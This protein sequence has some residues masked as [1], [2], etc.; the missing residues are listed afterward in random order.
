MNSN[1]LLGLSILTLNYKNPYKNYITEMN[2]TLQWGAVSLKD[3]TKETL[4]EKKIFIFLNK[5]LE[6][7]TWHS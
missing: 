2:L 3:T 4:G 7:L 1:T 6:E 5:Y